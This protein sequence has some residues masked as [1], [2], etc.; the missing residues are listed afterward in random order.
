MDR[1]IDPASA[2]CEAAAAATYS[3]N[4]CRCCSAA[5]ATATAAATAVDA[6][7]WASGSPFQIYISTLTSS[8]LSYVVEYTYDFIYVCID[9]KALTMIKLASVGKTKYIRDT[10]K[11]LLCK[12]QVLKAPNVASS[13]R[14]VNCFQESFQNVAII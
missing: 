7:A 6:D 13:R 3:S 12:H 2:V 1:E 4:P 8:V 14:V 5:T 11:Y 9:C 10:L